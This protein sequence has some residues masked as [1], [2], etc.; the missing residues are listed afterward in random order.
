MKL[1]IPMFK[2]ELI[3]LCSFFTTFL[4]GQTSQ[5]GSVPAQ[6]PNFVLIL[7]DDAALQDFGVYGGEAYTPNIDKLAQQ[8]II[9]T[10]YH[11]SLM[12]SLIH[13]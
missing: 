4:L 5:E 6:K 2:F 8:G 9:F 13:I 1:R 7:V 10:N 12:L 3:I 11:S